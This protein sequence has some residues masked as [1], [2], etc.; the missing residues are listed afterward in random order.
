MFR[1]RLTNIGSNAVE[2]DLGS[3][4][5]GVLRSGVKGCEVYG[6]IPNVAKIRFSVAVCSKKSTK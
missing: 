5:A 1:K 3:E 2:F 4:G 6:E